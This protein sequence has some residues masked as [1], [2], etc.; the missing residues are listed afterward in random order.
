[1]SK[2]GRE[3]DGEREREKTKGK[4]EREADEYHMNIERVC[5]VNLAYSLPAL[6]V[7]SVRCAGFVGISLYLCVCSCLCVLGS[8]CARK[9]RGVLLVSQEE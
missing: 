6:C 9:G 1:M 5:K 3:R 4:G 8:A 2:T 7:N